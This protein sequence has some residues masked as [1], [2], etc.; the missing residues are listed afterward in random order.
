MWL[1]TTADT[2]LITAARYER[3]QLDTVTAGYTAGYSG[4]ASNK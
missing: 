1:D 2:Q 3:I 4:S